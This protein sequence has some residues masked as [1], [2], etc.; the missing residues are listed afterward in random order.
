M[1]LALDVVIPLVVF[2]GGRAAGL[3][4][5]A[6]LVASGIAPAVG[7]MLTWVRQ[8][9][10]DATAVFV[11]AAMVLSSLVALLSGDPRALLARE[12]WLTAAIGTW[13]LASLLLDRPFLLDLTIKVTPPGAARRL[14]DLWRSSPVFHRWLVLASMAWG[15]A[16]MLD[17]I[18]RVIMAYELPVDSVPMLSSV[19][20]VAAIVV[21]QGLVMIHGRR[22]GALALVRGRE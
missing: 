18:G 21:A 22:S 13:I 9:R 14:E 2:Y 1:A 11:I 7:I 3:S 19:L 10:L 5:W 20:L 8:R 15:G 6:A 12:S 16:F 4:Q 17:A